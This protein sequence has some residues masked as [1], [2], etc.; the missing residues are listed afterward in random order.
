MSEN[1]RLADYLDHIQQAATDARSFVQG[2][3]KDDFLTDRRTQQAS[4]I[5]I[6]WMCPKMPS[7]SSRLL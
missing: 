2:L 3:A 5:T 4:L 6:Y 1:H 7:S